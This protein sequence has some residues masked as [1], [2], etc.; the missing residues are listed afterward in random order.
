MC[1]GQSATP[2]SLSNPAGEAH[3]HTVLVRNVQRMC[4]L[5]DKLIHSSGFS[6]AMAAHA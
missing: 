5:Q 3:L 6:P 2:I 1:G 4:G